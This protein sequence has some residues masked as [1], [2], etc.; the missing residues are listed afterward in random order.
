METKIMI[1]PLIVTTLLFASFACSSSTSDTNYTRRVE[2]AGDDTLVVF[3][4]SATGL[5]EEDLRTALMREA[6]RAV[7][8]Q[9]GIH[10]RIESL[11]VGS[12]TLLEQ[13]STTGTEMPSGDPDRP[14]NFPSEEQQS[15]AVSISRERNGSIQVTYSRGPLQGAN[16]FEASAL[17]DRL[18]AGDTP[19]LAKPH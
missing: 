19:L 11:R 5:S 13:K 1:R 6:A 7:I 15:S 4:D 16:V 10:L 9:G 18:S 17:L 8:D 14:A 3:L 12:R 2:R